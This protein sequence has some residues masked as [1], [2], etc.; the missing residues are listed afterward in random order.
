MPLHYRLKLGRYS[1]D[2]SGMSP[3]YYAFLLE[4]LSFVALA[5]NL[6]CRRMYNSVFSRGH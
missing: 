3:S 1:V 5:E 6:L 4:T 2:I